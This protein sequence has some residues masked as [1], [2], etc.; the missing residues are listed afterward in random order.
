MLAPKQK[1]L[2]QTSLSLMKTL[3]SSSRTQ[4]EL[5]DVEFK[6]YRFEHKSQ[7][8]M[9]KHSDDED[10]FLPNITAAVLKLD[11]TDRKDGTF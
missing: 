5:L 7:S 9:Q 10:S 3:S 4:Q 1:T 2:T 11:A 6:M 8:G